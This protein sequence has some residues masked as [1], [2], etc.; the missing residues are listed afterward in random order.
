MDDYRNACRWLASKGRV[1][2]AE[3]ALL[4]LCPPSDAEAAAAELRSKDSSCSSAENGSIGEDSS[5]GR[6]DGNG[7]RNDGS[8]GG[9]EVEQTTWQLLRSPAVQAELRLGD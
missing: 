1:E 9:G 7:T 4:A 3:Q 5:R 6:H 2:E 8:G